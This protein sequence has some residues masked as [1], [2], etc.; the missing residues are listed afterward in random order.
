[1]RAGLPGYTNGSGTVT[2]TLAGLPDVITEAT[3][4]TTLPPILLNKWNAAKE[5]QEITELNNF[6]TT[7]NLALTPR[8]AIV[9][10]LADWVR[11]FGV[12]G[13]RVDTYKHVE[14]AAWAAMAQH[15]KTALADWKLANPNKKIDDL[16][17]WLVAEDFGH[18]PGKDNSMIGNGFDAALNFNFQGAA[19]NPL[20]LESTYSNYASILNPDSTWNILTYISSHDTNLFDR[21]DLMDGGTSLLLCPGAVQIFYGD[22]TAR[23]LGTANVSD[24]QQ[25]TRSPMNWA[26]INNM[27]LN[28]WKKLGQFRKKHPAI[29]AGS[30]SKI[31]TTPYA[32]SRSFSKGYVQDNVICVLGASGATSVNVSSLFPNGT[33]LKDFYTNKTATVT[34]GTVIFTANSNGVILIEDPNPVPR[35]IVTIAPSSSYSANPINVTLSASDPNNLATTIY[36][37]TDDNAT[38]SNLSAWTIYSAPFSQSTT[39]KVR[40]VAKNANNVLSAEK[41]EQYF[42]GSVP[43]FTVYFKKPA[44]W[45]ST[46]LKCYYWNTN[47]PTNTMPVVNWP[48]TTMTS[49]GNDWY[50]FTFNGTLSSNIIFNAGNSSMQTAD[51]SRSYS[52]FYENSAWSDTAPAGYNGC[53]G[54]SGGGGGTIT[55][56]DTL[57]I[58]FY[59]AL[60]WANPRMHFWNNT[61]NP[62]NLATGFPGITMNPVPNQAGWYKATIA[63]SKNSNVKFSDNG[64]NQTG[65][66]SRT[67]DGWYVGNG[68]WSDSNPFNAPNDITLEFTSSSWTTPYVFFWATV[69]TALSVSWPGVAMSRVGTSNVYRYVLSGKYFTNFI[70][71]NNGASQ[72]PDLST[73]GE[74]RNYVQD[75]YSTFTLIGAPRLNAKVYLANFDLSSNLL[76]NY[77][78]GNQS[79]VNFPL[80][81]PYAS[82]TFKNN[83]KHV[84]NP[85]VATTSAN[86]L[87]TTGN[88]AIVDWVFLEL[89]QGSSGTTSVA[90]TKA[91]LLQRDGDIVDT[92]GISAVRFTNAPA[93]SYYVAIRHRNHIGFR[94]ANL[95][96]LSNQ[97]T[98]LNFTNN[99]VA[100]HGSNPLYAASTTVSVMNGGDATMD[101]SIDSFDTI[102]W[103]QENGNFDNYWLNPD[104]NLD[105]SVDSFDTILWEVNNGKFEELE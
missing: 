10:W 65:D 56:V 95:V 84:R 70:F 87:A 11:E 88:N 28:H 38:T 1:M 72:S 31:S 8:N 40:A 45:T 66:L 74:S 57:D 98:I 61:P 37:T 24:A 60:N 82:N 14:G 20:N 64:N 91:A 43:D 41:S 100:I 9:K 67:N 104:Y 83:F 68:C 12:D 79:L 93:G 71:S 49:C 39:A 54:G 6:L 30:H 34:N 17:F 29:G 53:T 7:N 89:R 81:D 3:T 103:E 44:A 47:S 46:A 48:G 78:V 92:D 99:S 75:T 97:T 16:P 102:I 22:E 90:Y 2:G 51:L 5:A 36:Y 26:S 76:D 86:V 62:Y 85:I 77:L 55:P 69:P 52:G 80:S 96:P 35:P 4:A 13:F 50:S 42:I 15:C 27:V 33:L 94:T 63:G 21:G 58:H 32:F 59:N 19:A 105:G 25:N 18:G 101:G 23:P 73:C